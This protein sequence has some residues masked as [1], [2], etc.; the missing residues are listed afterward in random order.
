MAN[1]FQSSKQAVNYAKC[2]PTYPSSLYETIAE[3]LQ[4]GGGGGSKSTVSASKASPTIAIDVGCGTGQATAALA[5]S[6]PS[7]LIDHVVGVDPSKAQIENAIHHPRV[8]YQIGHETDLLSTISSLSLDSSTPML[9]SDVSVS[10]ITTAQAAHWF[11]IPKFYSE[12]DRLLTSR[13]VL[14]MWTYGNIQFPHDKFLQKVVCDDFYTG[15]LKDGGYWDARRQHVDDRYINIPLIS[16]FYP[17]NYYRTKRIDE[18]LDIT[19]T[20]STESLIGYLRSWSGYV[21]YCKHH[22]IKEGSIDDPIRNIQE[23]LVQSNTY[24]DENEIHV[25]WPV[26]LLLAVKQQEQSCYN[27]PKN[28]S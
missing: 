25:I 23:Q 14:A 27:N 18:G 11:D 17:H 15:L 24:D 7:H 22:Q 4:N 10:L 3:A 20:V 13:G 9:P 8:S 26:T 2:R 28:S 6:F 5:D 1:L 19:M 21:T 16:S 12:V